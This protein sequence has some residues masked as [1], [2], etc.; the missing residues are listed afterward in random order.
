MFCVT[1]RVTMVYNKVYIEGSNKACIVKL[2]VK[3]RV[4]S[5]MVELDNED[6]SSYK[7]NAR[8]K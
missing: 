8:I 2:Q 7:V 6:T 1:A 4:I 3:I 5:V